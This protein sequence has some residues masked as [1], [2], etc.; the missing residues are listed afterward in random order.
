MI[1][2]PNCLPFPLVSR[3]FDAQLLCP[4]SEFLNRQ[5][6]AVDLEEGVYLMAM[7]AKPCGR[8]TSRQLKKGVNL[9][10]VSYTH[11]ALISSAGVCSTHSKAQEAGFADLEHRPVGHLDL[12]PIDLLPV[13]GHRLSLI[14]I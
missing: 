5:I 1:Y 3:Y 13:D 10:A 8:Y 11:L 6:L 4:I 9:A 2:E 12:L 7:D 14:H